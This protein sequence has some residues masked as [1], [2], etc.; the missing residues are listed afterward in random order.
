MLICPRPS[1]ISEKIC[2]VDVASS[3]LYFI[4]LFCFLSAGTTWKNPN[5]SLTK[6]TKKFHVGLNHSPLESSVSKRAPFAPRGFLGQSALDLPK[7]VNGKQ[8]TMKEYNPLEDPHL[9][10]Y[11]ARK[12]GMM[13]SLSDSKQKVYIYLIHL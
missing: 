12:L 9:S 10:D 1:G 2:K 11:Y 8:Y 7:V 5:A 3:I 13:P 4:V 6:P